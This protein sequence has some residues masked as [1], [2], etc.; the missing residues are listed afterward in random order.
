MKRSQ[1]PSLPLLPA[2]ALLA[3]RAALSPAPHTHNGHAITSPMHN[4]FSEYGGG[5][6]G[7]GVSSAEIGAAAVVLLARGAWSLWDR[8]H[9]GVKG[10]RVKGPREESVQS[11]LLAL[12]QA[13]ALVGATRGGVVR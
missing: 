7:R 11:V 4:R 8:G 9:E 12:V 2:A 3:L 13:A 1:P 5:G 10:G 6:R